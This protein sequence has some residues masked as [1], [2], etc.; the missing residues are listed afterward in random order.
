MTSKI[1]Q[2]SAMQHLTLEAKIGSRIES[3]PLNDVEIA[4]PAKLIRLHG[5][6][7]QERNGG[8]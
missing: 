6:F 8:P 3:H 4:Y 5:E 2:T 1:I 7:T